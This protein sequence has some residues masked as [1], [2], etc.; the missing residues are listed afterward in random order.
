MWAQ[1]H[2]TDANKPCQDNVIR[3]DADKLA[4][5]CEFLLTNA[6]LTYDGVT[7]KQVKGV[8]MGLPTSPQFTNAY[9]GLYE[10]QALI[11]LSKSW[12]CSHT[13][14]DKKAMLA[15]M[16]Q[17]SRC[18]D[19]IAAYGW[20]DITEVQ[21]ILTEK[22]YP[23]K[24]KDKD[25]STIENPMKLNLERYGSS[26]HYLDMQIDICGNNFHT[27]VY[28]KRDHLPALKNY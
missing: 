17:W 12:Q 8:P 16:W 22:D 24:I 18:I 15:A 10:L 4:D 28:N 14:A 3:W 20:P 11:R 26:V 6:Y 13:E 27:T 7:Y 9:T 2:S 25:G 5:V 19:D 1:W 23:T 21:T